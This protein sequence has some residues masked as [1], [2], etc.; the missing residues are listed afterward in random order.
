[1]VKYDHFKRMPLLC[2]CLRL[3]TVKKKRMNT[4]SK[5]LRYGLTE[6]I[7][8]NF[9]PELFLLNFFYTVSRT[10]HWFIVIYIRSFDQNIE[11]YIVSV[12]D[13]S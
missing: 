9:K 13:I 1:M 4:L 8:W 6:E 2:K 12:A 10:C 7:S 5:H 11:L 3:W